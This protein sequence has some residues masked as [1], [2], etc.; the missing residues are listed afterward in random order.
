MDEINCD[1]LMLSLDNFL[2]IYI[3]FTLVFIFF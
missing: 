3:S 2:N 1:L